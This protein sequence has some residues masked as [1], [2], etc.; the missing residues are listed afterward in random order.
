LTCV[1]LN[2]IVSENAEIN[3]NDEKIMK[4]TE[5]IEKL[6]R[7]IKEILDSTGT[8]GAT[9]LGF[10]RTRLLGQEIKPDLMIQAETKEKQK[11]LIV[12]E[13]KSTGQPRYARMAANQLQSIRANRENVYGVFGAPFI[14]EESKKICQ[15]SGIG[16]LDLAGNCLFRFNNVYISVEG[17][18][19]PY[20][21]T[22]PLK[23]I[24]ATKSTRALRVLLCN[25]KRDWFVKDL[26][27]EANISLGQTSNLKKRLLEFEFIKEIDNEKAVKFRLSNPEA[28]LN[29]WAEYYSYRENRTRN[30][31]S[32]DDVKAIEKKLSDYCEKEQI[33]NAYTLT[34]GA[35]LVAPFLRYK[36]VFAYLSNSMEKVAL[37]LGWKEVSS[38][39]NITILEPYDEGVFY[40]LQEINGMKVVSDAQL[41]LDLKGYKERGEEA[42]QF[43]LDNRLRKQW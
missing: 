34:S 28:L 2:D 10:A 19:N 24:F 20:P 14:S 23:S 38:G 41:Y 7:S 35:S 6:Q 9:R 17:K 33:R 40:G 16:Y 18:P 25:P 1:S 15:E 39:P 8:V 22:R 11:Y 42:A 30:Y 13:V 3:K 27:K 43:L 4:E 37:A 26:A 36:R 21:S 29:R 32:L 31:Y 12:F 5:I